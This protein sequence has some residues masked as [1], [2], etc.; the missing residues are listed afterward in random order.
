MNKATT[1]PAPPRAEQRPFTYERHG[2]RIDDPYAWLRDKDYPK[3]DDKDV[4]DYLK[5]ENAFFE[6]AMKPHAA[7]VETLF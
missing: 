7:L 5:A 2:V 6:A 4:L 3:V 1:L